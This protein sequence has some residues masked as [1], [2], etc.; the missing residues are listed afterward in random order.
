MVLQDI[1]NEGIAS[2]AGA[3]IGGGAAVL[4]DRLPCALGLTAVGLLGRGTA[5]PAGGGGTARRGLRGPPAGRAARVK[6]PTVPNKTRGSPFQHICQSVR[7]L[8][9]WV[10]KLGAFDNP[11][12]E[13][14]QSRAEIRLLQEGVFTPFVGGVCGLAAPAAKTAGGDVTAGGAPAGG[15]DGSGP[16]LADGGDDA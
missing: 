4:S 9:Q 1:R 6:L 8:T 12:A 14:E 16:G 15:G 3:A 11:R 7:G 5:T 2:P 13:A 10:A